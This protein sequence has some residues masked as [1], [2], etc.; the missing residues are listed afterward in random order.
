MLQL[1]RCNG[2][3]VAHRL[4]FVCT[5]LPLGE[6]GVG[7]EPSECGDCEKLRCLLFWPG[8]GA[9]SIASLLIGMLSMHLVKSKKK[10]TFEG[11]IDYTIVWQQQATI[12][13]TSTQCAVVMVVSCGVMVCGGDGGVLWQWWCAVAIVVC[14]GNGGVLWW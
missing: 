2:P 4:R 7:C 13:S 10:V 5:S 1:D 8:L 14:C 6:V 9:L 12:Q 11:E 3:T